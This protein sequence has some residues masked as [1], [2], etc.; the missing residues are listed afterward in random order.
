MRFHANEFSTHCF[1]EV[2]HV[3]RIP[4]QHW[5]ASPRLKPPVDKLAPGKAESRFAYTGIWIGE[6]LTTLFTNGHGN[7]SQP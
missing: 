2:R 6:T 4:R 5:H 7:S 1:Y 3:A